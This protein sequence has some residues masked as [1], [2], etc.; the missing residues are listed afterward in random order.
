MSVSACV[1]ATLCFASTLFFDARPSFAAVSTPIEYNFPKLTDSSEVNTRLFLHKY[2]P[3]TCESVLQDVWSRFMVTN[4]GDHRLEFQRDE[5]DRMKTRVVKG[6]VLSDKKTFIKRATDSLFGAEGVEVI[7]ESYRTKDQDARFFKRL[8]PRDKNR[9]EVEQEFQKWTSTADNEVSVFIDYIDSTAIVFNKTP[10]SHRA[11]EM[12]F[13]TDGEKCYL[14]KLRIH[15]RTKTAYRI[16][17]FD[18]RS[19]MNLESLIV[20]PK[21]T[22]I[23]Q[24]DLSMKQAYES[25]NEFREHCWYFYRAEQRSN[26]DPAMPSSQ[27][28]IGGNN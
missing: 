17:N 24:K 13:D 7:I 20:N 10:D 1:I 14:K 5:K 15:D 25:A 28:P 18:S 16:S 21:Q 23:L 22:E 8:I 27:N 19:C 11:V 4:D 6:S 2:N 3:P 26:S 9:K 12:I